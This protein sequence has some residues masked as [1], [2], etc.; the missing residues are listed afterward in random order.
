MPCSHAAPLCR[1]NP[2]TPHAPPHAQLISSWSNTAII[3]IALCIYMFLIY[4]THEDLGSPGKV[5]SLPQPRSSCARS[6][7]APVA[8]EWR[9]PADHLTEVAVHVLLQVYDNLRLVEKK[10][11]VDKNMGGR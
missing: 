10:W 11:P 7:L 8:V 1:P 3:F 9:Q 2:C 4:G 5:R 6:C